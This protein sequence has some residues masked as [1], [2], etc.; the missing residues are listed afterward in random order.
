M[1]HSPHQFWVR[2]TF[3]LVGLFGAGLAISGV[4]VALPAPAAGGTCGP[5]RA[6]EAPIVALL[7]PV[8]IGAGPE[9]AATD[10]ASRAEWEAFVS[11]CQTSADNRGLAALA[12]LV[13]SMFVAFVGPM[14]W[15]RTR[16]SPGT[17]LQPMMEYEWRP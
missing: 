12:I 16:R 1:T 4:L 11:E 6:S 7:D 3:V 10:T 9:P 8:S 17:S 13:L 2:V 14:V 5:G 15:R